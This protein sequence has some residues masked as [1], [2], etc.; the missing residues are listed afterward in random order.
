MRLIHL[1]LARDLPDRAV[2]YG[3]VTFD[4]LSSSI[5]RLEVV[6]IDNTECTGRSQSFLFFS[7]VTCLRGLQNLVIIDEHA[8]VNLPDEV[9]VDVKDDRRLEC[10]QCL[11][12]FDDFGVKHSRQHVRNLA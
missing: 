3:T 12:L 10:R 9:G 7:S 4:W 1:R 8:L 2:D 6:A 11:E 5:Q